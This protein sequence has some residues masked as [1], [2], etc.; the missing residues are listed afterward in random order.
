MDKLIEKMGL[1]DIWTVLFPGAIFQLLFKTIFDYMLSLPEQVKNTTSVIERTFLF[2][3]SYIYE[4]GTVYELLIFLLSSY[5]VG[6]L[7]HEFSSIFKNRVMYKHGK[8]IELLLDYQGGVFEQEQIQVLMPMYIKLK[9]SDFTLNDKEKQREESRSLFH[10]IN[11]DMQRRKRANE[12]VKLNVIYNTCATLGVAIMLILC[13]A[14][15]FEIEFMI[16]KRQDLILSFI[17]LDVVLI[18]GI[19]ILL[20][21][22]KRYYRY[23]TKNIVLAYQ[24]LYISEE[25]NS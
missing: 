8:P 6:L 11:M 14:L 18:L 20:N 17:S 12:Y 2:C 9:G 19:Y 15:A 22:S 16:L 7:L 25:T 10:K 5:F 21:R 24:D 23:W 13:L 3:R 4:P 1:Y